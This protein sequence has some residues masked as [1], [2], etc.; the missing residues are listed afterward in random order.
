MPLRRKLLIAN[1]LLLVSLLAMAGLSLLGLR[2]QQDHLQASFREYAALQLV[3][4]G[5]VKRIAAR[6]KLADRA[7][8]KS[9]VLPELRMGLEDLRP[10]KALLGMYDRLLPAEIGPA[11]QA[12][13]KELTR[14]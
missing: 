3:E 2:R 13:A 11:D 9:A 4:S 8:G 7:E 14:S 6:P 1:A 10:Y 5:T 12:R